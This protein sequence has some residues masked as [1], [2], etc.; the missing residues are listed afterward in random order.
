M[1]KNYSTKQKTNFLEKYGYLIAVA[2]GVLLITVVLILS[3]LYKP[4]EPFENVDGPILFAMPV[5]DATI[6]KSYNGTELLYNPTLNVW[7]A[8]KAVDFL[9]SSNLNVCTAYDGVVKEVYTNYL[10]GT[11]IVIDHGKGLRTSY[12]SLDKDS[13]AVE[14][15]ATVKK[16]DKIGVASDSANRETNLGAYLHFITYD[17]GKKI[18]PSG[19]LNMELK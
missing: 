1:L 2:V 9:V 3:S 16:G 17:N 18:D 13:V 10:E 15:G 5:M 12:G 8:H 7:E 14:V 4:E 19:Y 6:H 11:V